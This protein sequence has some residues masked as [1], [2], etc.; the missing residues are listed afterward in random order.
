MVVKLP[1]EKFVEAIHSIVSL[2]D[3]EDSL[4]T[5]S[6]VNYW[7]S[8]SSITHI[9]FVFMASDHVVT[10][11]VKVRLIEGDLIIEI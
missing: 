7:E 8:I 3:V 2:R 5:L 11:S 4:L 9:C 6:Q 1:I 10:A